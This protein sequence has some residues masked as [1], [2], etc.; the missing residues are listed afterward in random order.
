[1]LPLCCKEDAFC[2]LFG[3]WSISRLTRKEVIMSWLITEPHILFDPLR[4][5][6][7]GRRYFRLLSCAEYP[8]GEV[9]GDPFNGARNNWSGHGR[10]YRST[11]QIASRSAR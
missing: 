10:S 9:L 7:Y 11:C 2:D 8:S 4:S 5:E 3:R 6:H 1:M